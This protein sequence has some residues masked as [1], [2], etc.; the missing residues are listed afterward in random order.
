MFELGT[1]FFCEAFVRLTPYWDRLE[2]PSGCCV[3]LP[4]VFSYVMRKLCDPESPWRFGSYTELAA[5]TVVFIL[6]DV[7]DSF[8]LWELSRDMIQGIRRLNSE[9]ILLNSCNAR[10]CLLLVEAIKGSKF[11]NCQLGGRS[12]TCFLV[13]HLGVPTVKWIIVLTTRSPR[14]L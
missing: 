3:K 6:F 12:T 13:F 9:T 4:P 11:R 14:N 8:R 5:N 1:E 7:F 2:V 10:E